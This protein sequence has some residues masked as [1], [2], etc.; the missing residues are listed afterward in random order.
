MWRCRLYSGPVDEMCVEN[1]RKYFSPDYLMDS[2]H[3]LH[4][5]SSLLYAL[6]DNKYVE[7]HTTHGTHLTD[8]TI[9]HLLSRTTLGLV[10]ISRS[11]VVAP[12]IFRQSAIVKKF[13]VLPDGPTF[14]IA[15]TRYRDVKRLHEELS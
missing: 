5:A 9:T 8:L 14:L 7:L 4:P 3:Q 11:L 13:L 6:A 10:Q 2:Y 12:D 15:R 1:L